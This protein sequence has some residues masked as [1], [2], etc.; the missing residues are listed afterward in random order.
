MP[1]LRVWWVLDPFSHMVMGLSIEMDLGHGAS[2]GDALLG[3][4]VRS[5]HGRY[6]RRGA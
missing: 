5:P 6:H 1:L 4:C 2:L 3:Q